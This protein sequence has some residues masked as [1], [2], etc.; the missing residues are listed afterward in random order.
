VLS[1]SKDGLECA[2]PSFDGAQDVVEHLA[3]ELA[4]VPLSTSGV[5]G[6]DG[7]QTIVIQ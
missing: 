4:D 5:P 3:V 2:G 1:L 7:R 6:G